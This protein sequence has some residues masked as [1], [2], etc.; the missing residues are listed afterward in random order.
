LVREWQ[1]A[2]EAAE[3][4]DAEKVGLDHYA[5]VK[6]FQRTRTIFFPAPKRRTRGKSAS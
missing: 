6:R 2:R 3:L 4:E 5:A 1:R